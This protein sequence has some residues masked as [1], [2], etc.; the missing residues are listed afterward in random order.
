[1]PE[2]IIKAVELSDENDLQKS[3]NYHVAAMLVDSRHAGLYGGTGRKADW[4][5]ALRI[6]NKTPLILSGGLNEENIKAALEKVAPHA[7]DVNSGVEIKPG[8]K[9]HKKIARILKIVRSADL[10]QN[11]KQLIFTTRENR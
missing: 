7:L 3:L 11:N 10:Q 9:D 5:L 4:E 1:M 6:K 2:M 8:K